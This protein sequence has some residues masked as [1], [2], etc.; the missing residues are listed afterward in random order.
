MA[1]GYGQK[2]FHCSC[3]N[4]EMGIQFL[5]I[6]MNMLV[7]LSFSTSEQICH[8]TVKLVKGLVS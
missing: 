3:Q 6:D 1:I 4:T 5:G 8:Q 2:R 7:L